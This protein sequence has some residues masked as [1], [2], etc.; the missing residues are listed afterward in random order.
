MSQQQVNNIHLF[1]GF[2]QYQEKALGPYSPTILKNILCLLLQNL[3]I[4][5]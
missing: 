4:G 5:I 1:P 2:H 3:Q